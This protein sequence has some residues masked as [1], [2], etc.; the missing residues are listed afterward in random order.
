LIIIFDSLQNFLQSPFAFTDG[1]RLVYNDAISIVTVLATNMKMVEK[2]VNLGEHHTITQ[3]CAMDL[4]SESL[5][6][7]WGRMTTVTTFFSKKYSKQ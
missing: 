1:E 7:V 5:L 2:Q 3:F 6:I 4:K